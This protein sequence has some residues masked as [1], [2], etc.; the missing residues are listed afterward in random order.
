MLDKK[1]YTCT[2]TR[3]WTWSHMMLTCDDDGHEKGTWTTA[4]SAFSSSSSGYALPCRLAFLLSLQ[5]VRAGIRQRRCA[6]EGHECCCSGSTTIEHLYQSVEI[7]CRWV[8]YCFGFFLIYWEGRGG[9]ENCL[10]SVRFL[11]PQWRR[12]II[13]ILLWRSFFSTRSSISLA[14]W[15]CAANPHTILFQVPVSAFWH[16]R[17]HYVENFRFR[18]FFSSGC[19]QYISETASAEPA[20]HDMSSWPVDGHDIFCSSFVDLRLTCFEWRLNNMSSY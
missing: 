4:L 3:W 17:I 20:P 6:S 12:T 16:M 10:D 7:P 14:S 2:W 5:S 11:A 13:V 1:T 18:V 15:G 19:F 8:D 9:G